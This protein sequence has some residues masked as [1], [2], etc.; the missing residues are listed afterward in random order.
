M[1]QKKKRKEKVTGVRREQILKAAGEIFTRK[2]FEAATIPEIAQAAGVAAGTIYLYFPN[3]RE[4]F[5]SAVKDI[6]ITTP[7]LDLIG[8]I[9]AGNFEDVF[10]NIIL[11]RF[12]LVKNKGETLARMPSLIGEVQRDPE[13]KALWLKDFLRPFLARMEMTYRM[14]S[15][16][17]K[18]RT[19]EP[20]VVVRMMGGM[21]FGF[22]MLRIM[23]GDTS[24]I[25]KLPPEKVADDIVSFVLHGLISNADKVK[26]DGKK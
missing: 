24:P 22:L 15:G 23:E 14:L 10:K 8:K 5:I 21:I 25:N 1:A 19:M 18:A 26:K 7:L 4:L 12:G 16:S 20:A 17:G 9:P 2:G 11:E 6:I 13:L 3:K